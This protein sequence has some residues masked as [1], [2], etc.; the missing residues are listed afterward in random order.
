[1]LPRS[2]EFVQSGA[3]G[4]PV[5]G[6]DRRGEAARAVL[7]LVGAMR[8]ADARTGRSVFPAAEKQAPEPLESV[9]HLDDV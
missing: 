7:A 1:M 2:K 8:E 5:V 3:A 9:V 4:R 6:F